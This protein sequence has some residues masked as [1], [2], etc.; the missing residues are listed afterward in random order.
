MCGMDAFQEEIREEMDTLYYIINNRLDI[1]EF[2]KATGELRKYQLADAELLRL[3]H[4]ACQ[5]HNLIYWLDWGTL[6]G[7]IRHNGFIPWDDDLDVC[8]PRDDY[9]KAKTVLTEEFEQLGFSTLVRNGM[10]IWDE[11]TGVS[12]D[13]FAVDSTK[14]DKNETTLEIKARE[15]LKAFRRMPEPYDDRTVRSFDELRAKTMDEEKG[16]LIY[17]SALESTSR[18]CTYTPDVI[19]PLCKHVFEQYEFMVPHNSNE[20]LKT[21][22]HDYM[23]YPHS[24]VLHHVKRG[25]P[26]YLRASHNN[27]NLDDVIEKLSRISLL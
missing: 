25:V 3:F 7:A 1:T 23:S 5:K 16:T 10:F 18:L 6:L 13:V 14:Y 12:L 11:I 2:P 15:F 22:F 21:Q 24:G 4:E 17:Y 27:E 26:T 20:Y 9:N 19:F 8:M